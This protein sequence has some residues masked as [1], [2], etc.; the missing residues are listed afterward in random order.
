[1]KSARPWLQATESRET[2][3]AVMA[4][5]GHP[6]GKIWQAAEKR[7]SAACSLTKPHE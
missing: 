5:E 7:I 4:I 6:S 3:S 1:M 2:A